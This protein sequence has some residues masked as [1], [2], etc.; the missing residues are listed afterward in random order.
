MSRAA[1][2]S[3][4]M[5]VGMN[6]IA[7]GAEGL[8]QS[9]SLLKRTIEVLC[10]AAVVVALVCLIGLIVAGTYGV[11]HNGDDFDFRFGD[12]RSGGG[13]DLIVLPGAFS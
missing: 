1:V 3:P 10:Y 5:E 13:G 6:A 9:A 7:R 12:G 11:L 2:V 8:A 4:G